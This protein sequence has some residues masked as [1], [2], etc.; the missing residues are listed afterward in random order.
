ME[1]IHETREPEEICEGEI[2][3][4]ISIGQEILS[5]RSIVKR[6][7]GDLMNKRAG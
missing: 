2:P 5:R 6:A 7:R 3:G 4:M 1:E